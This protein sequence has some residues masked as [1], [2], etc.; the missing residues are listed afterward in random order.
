LWLVG[1]DGSFIGI[2]RTSTVRIE[3][4]SESTSI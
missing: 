4:T 3:T 2:S 1:S